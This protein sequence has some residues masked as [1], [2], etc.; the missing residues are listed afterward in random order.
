MDFVLAACGGTCFGGVVTAAVFKL[1]GGAPP[2]QLPQPNASPMWS[3][4]GSPPSHIR[5][6]SPRAAE[7]AKAAPICATASL[8]PHMADFNV[9]GVSPDMDKDVFVELMRKLIGESKFLQNNPRLGVVPEETRAALIVMEELQPFCTEAGGPLIMERL[10]YVKGRANL[11][12]VYPG[13]DGPNGKTVSF[14]GTHFDVVPADP[15]TWDMDPFTL[16]IEGGRLYGRGTTDCLCHVALLTCVLKELGKNKPKLK[17][18]VVVVFIAA[19]EGGESGVGVD[20]VLEAGK[21]EEAR[22]GPLFWVDAADSQ[23]CCGSFGSLGWSLKC[24]GR[25]FH[26][27]FPHK[28]I[29]SIEIASEVL[30]YVQGRFYEEFPGHRLDDTYQ[31]PCGST[32]KPTQIECASGSR[33]QICPQTVIHGDIRLSPFYDVQDVVESVEQ[34][35]KE[36]NDDMEDLGER[37]GRGPW[38]RF[39][40]PEDV[41]VNESEHRRGNVELVWAGTMDLFRM[42]AG[43]ASDLQS[44][45]HLALVQACRETY[46]KVAPFSISGSLPLVASMQKAGFDIQL[47]GFGLMSVYHGV[48]E[49]CEME[50]MINAYKVILRTI[51]LLE[52]SA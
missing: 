27:G 40:L 7:L 2:K 34:Y 48:N 6:D 17:Q 23:P 9:L 30:S 11:K 36:I 32:M 1:R 43:F 38:S 50:D 22:N 19:E 12:I 15:E 44:P 33:N 31:F 8:S 37:S 10:E 18:N 49:Y 42:Y 4:W 26:S 41:A 29:N 21:L 52:T 28:G 51:I 20:R 45:G 46:A 14:V 13:T 35:V 25:V 24:N 5:R 39:V 16:T 47:C 3:K